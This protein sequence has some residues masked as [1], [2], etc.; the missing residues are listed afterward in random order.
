M[1]NSLHSE[2]EYVS[3]A[4]KSTTE[5]ALK[6]TMVAVENHDIDKKRRMQ[7]IIIS[8]IDKDT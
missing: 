7:N 3:L 5:T 8:G 1:K 6:D 2:E 4:I